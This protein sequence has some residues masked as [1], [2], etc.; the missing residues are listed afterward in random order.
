MEQQEKISILVVEDQ[1]LIAD[2]LVDILEMDLGYRV[3][4]AVT[5]GE[6]A[7]EAAAVELPDLLLLDI[8]IEGEMDGIATAEV[9]NQRYDFALPIIYVSTHFDANTRQR[10]LQTRPANYLVKPYQDHELAFAI[11][12]A[13]H[14]K[15]QGRE[16]DP[17]QGHQQGP[18]SVLVE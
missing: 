13:L 17:E 9:F 14:N 10:A 8:Q 6:A 4:A 7:L 1:L 12:M 18:P 3:S 15:E 2:E 16:V 11:Q 5:S